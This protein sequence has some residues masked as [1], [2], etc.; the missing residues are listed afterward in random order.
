[1]LQGYRDRGRLL[2]PARLEGLPQRAAFAVLPEWQLLPWCAVT[3]RVV[4]VWQ[5]LVVAPLQQGKVPRGI[6]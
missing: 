1:M 5:E 4:A 3:A 6:C 2:C